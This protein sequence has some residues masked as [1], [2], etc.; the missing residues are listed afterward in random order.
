ML[1]TINT[2]TQSPP[3]PLSLP[4]GNNIFCFFLPQS[5]CFTCNFCKHKPSQLQTPIASPDHQSAINPSPLAPLSGFQS[6]PCLQHRASPP[7]LP[8]LNLSCSAQ[9]SP[10]RFRA[11]PH[12]CTRPAFPLAASLRRRFLPSILASVDYCTAVLFNPASI[13]NRRRPLPDRS[14]PA[15][16]VL[17]SAL[18]TTPSII[19]PSHTTPRR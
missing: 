8:V 1:L 11:S 15:M 13:P 18:P 7:L 16:P 4:H 9:L 17:A 6:P 12:S 3:H 14:S 5:F 2:E 19:V 10:P